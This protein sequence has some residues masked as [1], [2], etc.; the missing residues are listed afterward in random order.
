MSF[1]FTDNNKDWEKFT[2]NMGE[3]NGAFAKVGLLSTAQNS[4]K[5][6]LAQIGFWNEFGTLSKNGNQHIPPRPF[7]RQAADNNRQSVNRL[8][9]SLLNDIMLGKKSVKKSLDI[10]GLRG[11]TDIKNSITKLRTPG[12]SDRTLA[13]QGQKYNN[14]LIYTGQMRQSVS[15]SVHIGGE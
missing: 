7:M 8:K 11:A 2:K 1:K 5:T 6:S 10:L 9:E 12:K 15:Y 4:E 13:I 14:P 3:V